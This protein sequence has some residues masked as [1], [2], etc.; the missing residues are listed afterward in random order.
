[1]FNRKRTEAL[2]KLLVAIKDGGKFSKAN[3]IL[4]PLA[5]AHL[6]AYDTPPQGWPAHNVRLT[7]GGESWLAVTRRD[8]NL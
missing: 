8:F 1:M 6:I 7:P 4:A 2:V 5:Q 3:R